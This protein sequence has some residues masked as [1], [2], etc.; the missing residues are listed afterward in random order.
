[1]N[2]A[3]LVAAAL[4]LAPIAV[5]SQELPQPGKSAAP[6]EQTDN[7]LQSAAEDRVVQLIDK[8]AG[9]LRSR[10]GRFLRKG[11][12]R[13]GAGLIVHAGPRRSAE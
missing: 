5:W 4:V 1:M 10:R 3:V 2:K 13:W 7:L 8:V 12:I 6:G 9:R 11:H